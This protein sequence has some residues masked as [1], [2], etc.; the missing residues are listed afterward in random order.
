MDGD[1]LCHCGVFY[2]SLKISASRQADARALMTG[3]ITDAYANITTVKLFSH[4]RRELTY[5][6][7]AMSQFWARCMSKCAGCPALSWSII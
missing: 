4:S 3:R 6:K 2:P 7:D 5:A 1:V